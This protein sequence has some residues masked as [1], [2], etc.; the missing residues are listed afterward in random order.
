[1]FDTRT[2][3]WAGVTLGLAMAAA[4]SAPVVAQSSDDY[5]Y[6]AGYNAGVRL[7][8]EG[9]SLNNLDG[10]P[11]YE[12]YL[13]DGEVR[14][15]TVDISRTGNYVLVIG[16]DDDTVDLDAYFS[17]IGANDTTM[18]PTAFFDFNVTQPGRFSYQ[19]D[20][21]NCATPSCAVYAVLLSVGD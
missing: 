1:M 14:T 16:G 5:L 2:R 15:I 10:A 8:Q 20:M 4:T 19:I 6:Q 17:Q 9:Y 12:S 18:G 7:Q 3:Q 21:V 13:D 11:Y